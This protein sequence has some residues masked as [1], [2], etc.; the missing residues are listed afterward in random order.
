MYSTGAVKAFERI[1]SNVNK[2]VDDIKTGLRE[3]GCV[4][5]G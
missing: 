2:F 1:T 5:T 3:E 4:V